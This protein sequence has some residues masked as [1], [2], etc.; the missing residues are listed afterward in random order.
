LVFA[1]TNIL[2]YAISVG[3]DPRHAAAQQVVHQL[4]DENRLCLSTQVLQE[5]FHVLTRKMGVPGSQ[6][7][8]TVEDFAEL[9]LFT[10]GK[11]AIVA[12]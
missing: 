5:L 2:V 10:V 8:R 11:R 4:M 3:S 1:G 12:A 9:H 7:V 6:A